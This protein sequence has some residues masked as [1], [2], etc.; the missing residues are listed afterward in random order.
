MVVR[1]QLPAGVANML[2]RADW[3]AA[4][5]AESLEVTVQSDLVVLRVP[6]VLVASD[7]TWMA[8]DVRSG[9]LTALQQL[10]SMFSWWNVR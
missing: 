6:V 4:T 7:I 10:Q 8:E 3:S 2:R 1:L 5:R 9:G